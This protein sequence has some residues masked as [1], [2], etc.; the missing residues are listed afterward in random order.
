MGPTERKPCDDVPLAQV[1]GKGHPVEQATDGDLVG[2][3]TVLLVPT[4]GQRAIRV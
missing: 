4:F 3:V 1:I 2:L